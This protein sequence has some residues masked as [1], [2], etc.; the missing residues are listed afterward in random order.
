MKIEV[1]FCY[2][3]QVV[4][5]KHRNPIEIL[6]KDSVVVNLQEY[7]ELPIAFKFEDENLYWD[8][9]RLWTTKYNIDSQRNKHLVTL[10]TI[11]QNTE[12]FGKENIFSRS[13]TEFPFFSFWWDAKIKIQDGEKVLTKEEAILEYKD[14][15]KDNREEIVNEIKKIANN[16]I[17]INNIVCERIG[18]PRYKVMTFGLGKNHG[19]TGL[20]KTTYYNENISKDSYFN[21]FQYEDAKKF[22]LSLAINRGDTDYIESIK[23]RSP[24]EILIPEAVKLNIKKSKE[25]YERFPLYKSD[26]YEVRMKVAENKSTSIK[27]LEILSKDEHPLVR[28]SVA[29][30]KST[31]IEILKQLTKDENYIV[32][33]NAN[34]NLQEIL[35]E[36]SIKEIENKLINNEKTLNTFLET[37]KISFDSE[38][39][40]KLLEVYNETQDKLKIE[41][42][43]LKTQVVDIDTNNFNSL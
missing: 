11:K 4:K 24:I 41:L 40:K 18:E 25:F 5:P 15:V 9:K 7:K 12:N 32:S 14:Y 17:F 33:Q 31:S 28:E 22:A 38:N 16:M 34:S 1:P 10:D 2:K 6:L 42:E 29:L 8:K 23:N 35:K 21:A 26:D 19:G 37:N 30:N 20:L 3:A 39:G 43:N 13:T 27:V 36:K